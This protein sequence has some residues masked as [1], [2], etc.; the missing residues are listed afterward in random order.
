MSI[1]SYVR[2]AKDAGC[3]PDQIRNFLRA[4]LV[5]TP[6]QLRAAA[7]CRQCD[8]PDGPT[9]I[10][11]GGARGGGKSHF[12][13]AQAVCDDMVRFP[14]LK[15][16]YLR[17]VGKSAKEAVDD[18]R[19][20]VLHST[21]HEWTSGVLRLPNG[22]RL[23]SGHFR[24][25][26][27]I[28]AYLGLQYDFAIIEEATQISEAKQTR[29]NTCV[30]SAKPGWRPRKYYGTNPG[31]VGHGWFKKLFIEPMRRGAEKFTRFVQATIRDN[32][33]VNP[34]Y[35][36]SLESLTGWLRKAWLDGDWDVMSGQFFAT[37]SREH[38]VVPAIGRIPSHW[39][40]WLSLDYGFR[41]YTVVYLMAEDSQ[42]RIFVVDEHAEQRWLPEQHCQ[43]I[44]AMLA[45][46]GL[47]RARVE[48]F[49][50]GGDVF[51]TDRDAGSVADDY[52]ARGYSL[53]RANMARVPGAAMMLRLLRDPRAGLEPLL[54]VC[55]S[56]PMLIEQIP[57]M[58][59]DEHRPE[60][61]R[62][63]DADEDGKGGD[64]AYDSAR[65]G[66]MYRS[67]G[68]RVDMVDDLLAA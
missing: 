5:L 11:Y 15:G 64:D 29:I 6:K 47:D 58:I 53:E 49:V 38:H 40:C 63:V 3:P 13:V 61:P 65:Y 39:R 17:K 62:K 41:H 67:G 35:R 28:D 46:H 2:A 32:P 55:E 45:R 34:E 36:S 50:A 10:G 24:N 33:F 8:R 48:T 42:G 31:G 25:E 59:H 43:A 54:F 44:D 66:V 4:N 20:D 57:A 18:L 51:Q 52:A 37:W 7:H 1:E 14:G 22:S 68:N 9:D 19:R 12:W 27:D 23:I 16:L 21:P 26:G 60:T 30:R 56:C